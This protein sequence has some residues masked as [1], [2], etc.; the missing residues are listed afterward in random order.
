[1]SFWKPSAI[2]HAIATERPAIFSDKLLVTESLDAEKEHQFWAACRKSRNSFLLEISETPPSKCLPQ[3]RHG[4][5]FAANH[6]NEHIEHPWRTCDG[7]CDGRRGRIWP[8]RR[9]PICGRPSQVRHG[10]SLA[11]NHVNEHVEH[12]WR[13]CG[14]PRCGPAFQI[15]GI[16]KIQIH[17]CFVNGV[18][19]CKATCRAT[20]SALRLQKSKEASNAGFPRP[21]GHSV[22]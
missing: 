5:S 21:R 2:R 14:R 3:V 22:L 18:C 1:L 11:A 7:R 20:C 16:I 19:C 10:C 4:C 9:T 17:V 15:F 12:P 8:S 13:T 6:V